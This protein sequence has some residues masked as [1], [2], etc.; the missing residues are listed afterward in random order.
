MHATTEYPLVIC[1]HVWE[2]TQRLGG[3]KVGDVIKVLYVLIKEVWTIRSH[4]AD[5]IS[6]QFQWLKVSKNSHISQKLT[7][8][9]ASHNAYVYA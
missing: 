6:G 4:Q 9:I 8:E 2:V 1:A 5:M 7:I 3:D